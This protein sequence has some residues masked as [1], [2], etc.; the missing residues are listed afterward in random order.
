[1]G[2]VT[3]AYV[4]TF[5]NI[6]ADSE[7]DRLTQL[8]DIVSAMFENDL[9]YPV[10]QRTVVE[11][12]SGANDPVL[13]LNA[14]NVSSITSIYV[15]SSGF[16]GAPGT[17]FASGT[18]LTNGVDYALMVEEDGVSWGGMV[19]RL[20]SVWPTPQV[21]PSAGLNYERDQFR[22]NIKATFVAGYVEADIP[23]DLKYAACLAIGTMRRYQKAGGVVSGYSFEGF[24]RQFSSQDQKDVTAVQSVLANHRKWIWNR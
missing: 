16:F 7:T 21:K 3:E 2:I 10:E 6:T 4:R 22:G 23:A 17:A 5:F 24:S 13:F 11:Y 20:N 9:G 19:R 8:I 14:R 1:M 18:L 12:H 15:D